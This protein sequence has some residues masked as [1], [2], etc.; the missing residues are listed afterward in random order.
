[1]C[2]KLLKQPAFMDIDENNQSKYENTEIIITKVL[3]FCL[4]SNLSSRLFER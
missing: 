1:M 3:R 4:Q 2:G